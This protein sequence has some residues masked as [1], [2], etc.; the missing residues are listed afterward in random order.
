MGG[1]YLEMDLTF[2]ILSSG[3]V[4]PAVATRLKEEGPL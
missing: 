1:Q 3:G 4:S 2:V